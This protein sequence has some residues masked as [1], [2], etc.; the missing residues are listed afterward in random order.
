MASDIS[1]STKVFI[2][3]IDPRTSKRLW[4]IDYKLVKDPGLDKLVPSPTWTEVP[5]EARKFTYEYACI[6][7]ERWYD[8]Y[9][10]RDPLHFTLAA[11]DNEPFLNVRAPGAE[12]FV[13]DDRQVMQYKGLIA[14]PYVPKGWFVRLS[15]EQGLIEPF[16]RP[17]VEEA[18]DA[19]INQGAFVFAEK[20][21]APVQVP[22]PEVKIQRGPVHRLRPGSF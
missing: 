20:A 4:M 11:G 5:R 10:D 2:V 18:V 7:R 13:E 14:R 22:A 9:G 12:T 1:A 6:V 21:A 17:T 15:S 19:V 8:A 3:V 16:V